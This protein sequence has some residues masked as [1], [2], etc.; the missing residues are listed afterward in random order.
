MHRFIARYCDLLNVV[1]S[2]DGCERIA[3]WH[4]YRCL[5]CM[6]M[7][8]CKTCFLSE[9]PASNTSHD[10]ENTACKVALT[11]PRLTGVCGVLTPLLYLL[12]L[13]FLVRSVPLERPG[14]AKPEGHEDDHEMVNMEYACDHC[15]GLIVGSRINCNVCE[16][17]DLCF[18]CYNAKKY[19]DR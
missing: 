14:G 15:Q 2:C 11:L 9:T 10:H 7:D 6:D 8:L 5:Q 18:G 3:P 1:I 16:D 19:P 12:F 13:P 4:R 17:F